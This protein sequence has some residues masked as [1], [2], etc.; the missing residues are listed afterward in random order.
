[1]YR[2]LVKCYNTVAHELNLEIIPFGEV[3]QK[4]RTIPVYDYN[5]G[6]MSLCRDGF[7]MNYIYGRYALAATWYVYVV[8]GN[9][10]NNQ[11]IPPTVDGVTA[12]NEEL[13][14]IKE[15]IYDIVNSKR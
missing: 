3:I 9:I 15:S 10:L 13:Q 1:M 12:T 14:I 2:A 5:T 6:G 8:K 7:H 11:F 4:L